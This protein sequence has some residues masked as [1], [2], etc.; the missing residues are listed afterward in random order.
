MRPRSEKQKKYYARG[1]KPVQTC[2]CGHKHVTLAIFQKLSAYEKGYIIYL[3]A[4]HPGSELKDHQAN[5]YSKST[6][7]WEWFNDGQNAAMLVA[8]DSEE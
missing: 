2:N 7:E 6:K 8:Q 4:E 5:P 1:A 3:Q